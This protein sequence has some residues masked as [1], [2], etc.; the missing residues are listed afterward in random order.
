MASCTTAQGCAI[1]QQGI[2]KNANQ[3]RG[4]I[5]MAENGDPLENGVAEKVNGL[6]K[7]VPLID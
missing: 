5:S 1:L 3:K 4:K 2:C 7:E 6:L